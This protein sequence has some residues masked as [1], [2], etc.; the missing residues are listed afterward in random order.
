M[1][2]QDLRETRDALHPEYVRFSEAQIVAGARCLSNKQADSCNVDRDDQ[3]TFYGNEAIEEFRSAVDA[4]NSVPGI[5]N[6]A[7]EEGELTDEQIF[8]I[9]QELDGEAWDKGYDK[10]DTIQLARKIIA[11]DRAT[12]PTA[13]TAEASED[14]RPAAK[15]IVESGNGTGTV[16]F[17]PGFKAQV[18]MSLYDATPTATNT[19]GA[20]PSIDTPELHELLDSMRNTSTL[21]G[22]NAGCCYLIAHIDQHVAREVAAQAGNVLDNTSSVPSAVAVPEGYALLPLTPTPEMLEA[23]YL[24]ENCGYG[25]KHFTNAYLAMVKA[26]PSPAKESK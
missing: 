15:I 23:A 7:A 1:S 3:W 2:K 26:A 4:A 19:A 10:P 16:M 20:V 22:W 11:A 25:A 8:M 21:H 18:G 14:A 5:A 13:H 24:A 17:A 9:Y 12:R 6:K